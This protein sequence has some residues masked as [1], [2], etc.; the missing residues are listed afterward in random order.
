[1][2]QQNFD[3]SLGLAFNLPLFERYRKN[4][5]LSAEIHHV[6]G[7]RGRCTG[8]LQLVEG[9][10]ISCYVVDKNDQR[11]SISQST[12]VDVDTKRGPFEWVLEALPPPAPTPSNSD[13]DRFPR[14]KPYGS[15][16]S[17]IMPLESLKLEG[18]TNQQI[19]MLRS[20]YEVI[21]GLRTIE[22]IQAKVP[23]DPKIT[24]EALQVLL[25]LKVII[26][27]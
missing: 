18:W 21:N 2:D 20:V 5:I 19:L 11:I 25:A 10:V 15:I 16:P 24:V 26:I 8:Y 9:K 13:S 22:E 23:L 14:I 12:L 4:G 6:P 17:V 3:A 7:V 27:K 1:M